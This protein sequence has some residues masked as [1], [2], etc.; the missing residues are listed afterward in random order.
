MAARCRGMSIFP[1]TDYWPGGNRVLRR[2]VVMKDRV[3]ETSR[4]LLSGLDG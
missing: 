4:A 2:A 3:R 1:A